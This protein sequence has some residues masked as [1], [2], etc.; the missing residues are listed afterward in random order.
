M[1]ILRIL[2][3]L[4]FYASCAIAQTSVQY[5]HSVCNTMQLQ[6]ASNCYPQFSNSCGYQVTH[7]TPQNSHC[8]IQSGTVS[9]PYSLV[10]VTKSNCTYFVDIA[11]SI[12]TDYVTV[13]LDLTGLSFHSQNGNV[14]RYLL[15]NNTASL[16]LIYRYTSSSIGGSSCANTQ[17]YGFK[18]SLEVPEFL[19]NISIIT[20]IPSTICVGSTFDVVVLNSS[21]TTVITGLQG[22][23]HSRV[24]NVWTIMATSPG[25]RSISFSD[26]GCTKTATTRGLDQP[27]IA[28]VIRESECDPFI[29]IES[30]QNDERYIFEESGIFTEALRYRP[31]AYVQIKIYREKLN[32]YGYYC[33]SLPLIINDYSGSLDKIGCNLVA[34]F[35]TTDESQ[36]DNAPNGQV[37]FEKTL[38]KPSS[39]EELSILKKSSPLAN[40]VVGYNKASLTTIS[41]SYPQL[42]QNGLSNIPTNTEVSINSFYTGSNIIGLNLGSNAPPFSSE[43]ASDPSSF[44][45]KVASGYLGNKWQLSSGTTLDDKLTPKTGV[46]TSVN[47]TLSTQEA[48]QLKR[49]E[50]SAS[51]GI[52]QFGKPSF[53]VSINNLGYAPDQLLV[54]ETT[55]PDGRKLVNFS[56][57]VGELVASVVNYGSVDAEFSYYLYDVFGQLRVVIPPKAVQE[58][59][60]SSLPNFD[61]SD[62]SI[63]SKYATAY[64]YDDKGNQ[65]WSWRPGGA[66][67]RTFYDF[68]NRPV[69]IQNAMMAKANIA[70]I[71][72]Y[73]AHGRELYSGILTN[74]N[75]PS[76]QVVDFISPELQ[77]WLNTRLEEHELFKSDIQNS[78]IKYSQTVPNGYTLTEISDIKYYTTYDID[79]DGVDDYQL[80]TQYQSLFTLQS[81]VREYLEFSDLTVQK[82]KVRTATGTDYTT[83]VYFYDE[84]SRIC[85]RQVIS[86]NGN[87][88]ILTYLYDYA[89]QVLKTH[90]VLIRTTPNGRD[91]TQVLD[92]EYDHAG[93]LKKCTQSSPGN[94]V[95]LAAYSY[96][97]L[98]NVHK[99]VLGGVQDLNYE[100][101]LHGNLLSINQ[102]NS[103]GSKYF[104]EKYFYDELDPTAT[105]TGQL[106]SINGK[107]SRTVWNTFRADKIRSY[108][109]VYDDKGRLKDGKYYFDNGSGWQSGNTQ[110]NYT[111]NTEYDLNGNITRFKRFGKVSSSSFGLI[112]DLTYNYNGNR[113][114][115][116]TDASPQQGFEVK[117]YKPIANSGAN[118][119]DLNGNLITCPGKGISLIEY[120]ISTNLVVKIALANGN[121]IT[122][123]RDVLGQVIETK[124]LL[125]N[126][127]VENKIDYTGG[128]TVVSSDYPFKPEQV[129]ISHPTGRSL[130]VQSL[131]RWINEFHI[132]DKQ[133]SLRIAFRLLPG[134]TF[135]EDPGD[136]ELPGDPIEPIDIPSG[137]R[138]MAV[139][140]ETATMED[141][142]KLDENQKF[143]NLDET[144]KQDALLAV[145]G[146]YVANLNAALGKVVGPLKKLYVHKGD[147]IAADIHT[148]YKKTGSN[149]WLSILALLGSSV[150]LNGIPGLENSP[151]FQTDPLLKIGILASPAVLNGFLSGQRPKAYLKYLHLDKD[152]N[153][154]EALTIPVTDTGNGQW[155]T[156]TVAKKIA[157]EG[158]VYLYLANESGDNVYADNFRVAQ[159][160]PTVVQEQHYY[161]YGLDILPINL[162]PGD[163]RFP[164]FFNHK[165]KLTAFDLQ[166]LDYG[167]RLYDLQLSRWSS[168]DPLYQFASPYDFC[169]GDPVN[170]IDPDGRFV[171][172]IAG[173]LIGFTSGYFSSSG[174][175][176]DEAW[177][178]AAVGAAAG[179]A[180]DIVV[181]S[182]G[183]ATPV[184]IGLAAGAAGGLVGYTTNSLVR[185]ERWDP[186]QAA[187]STVT[188]ALTGGAMGY[189]SQ[190]VGPWLGSKFP[191]TMRWLGKVSET[192]YS[193]LRKF[194][195]LFTQKPPSS[196]QPPGNPSN[197]DSPEPT[198][199]GSSE[200]YTTV[201]GKSRYMYIDDIDGD[202]GT[203]ERYVDPRS[204]KFTDPNTT[205]HH[206]GYPKQFD[207]VENVAKVGSNTPPSSKALVNFS[208][209]NIKG[210]V[211][212][213]LDIKSVH[214][215]IS[216]YNSGAI[217]RRHLGNGDFEIF[218]NHEGLL[219]DL[220]DGVNWRSMRIPEANKHGWN[221]SGRVVFSTDG[222]LVYFTPDHYGTFILLPLK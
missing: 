203:I 48:A 8:Y 32:S 135:G 28:S 83:D 211:V 180:A 175:N 153:L 9:H 58:I 110:E 184:A 124:Y 220:P 218:R 157:Q 186:G 26:N 219:P 67:Q 142:F 111:T 147:S 214:A 21:T 17:Y 120:D 11:K 183:T 57:F 20:S 116:V 114:T 16:N 50:F 125:A 137:D 115:Q 1:K 6:Q 52:N 73:D 188:G 176:W 215:R 60:S 39:R 12:N 162:D 178:Q 130:Y 13:C 141:A 46:T 187:V 132:T 189:V 159:F 30:P 182:M 27:Q 24:G 119:Y 164:F 72:R 88:Q 196:S 77:D 71:V 170:R 156:L 200:R 155:E 106:P 62:N 143:D 123:L 209:L 66:F 144:R 18:L 118:T 80:N 129:Y 70:S 87:K 126:G 128:Q 113:L 2:V 145:S 44:S 76:S 53:V 146:T 51:G 86:Y 74:S 190:Q 138:A 3:W 31:L 35:E 64:E 152:S 154:V 99:I 210:N 23:S 38:I 104:G 105:N 65:I 85:Q 131:Q 89:G 158:T 140:E 221:Y 61:W 174:G 148:Y 95:V 40:D 169:G 94:P 37:T 81:P 177:K 45:G 102:P 195:N 78:G 36:L 15:T 101:D 54:N 4:W 93:R 10:S 163:D 107:V 92:N 197:I 55:G 172:T 173:G 34:N 206:A 191:K 168:D 22:W 49:F 33:R 222:S 14:T 108:N 202:F 59:S 82:F 166:Y 19:N 161:P 193:P 179:L 43:S 121:S 208:I 117:D 41:K 201:S 199:P 198:P 133:G 192:L 127:F 213:Y 185:G 98:G 204:P 5:S 84:N 25:F 69:L 212:T 100:Y 29:V 97:E 96:N 150:S 139:H 167:A 194:R 216:Q 207:F 90:K 217:G 7:A 109:Y 136:P 68:F 75:G 134:G 79:N 103:L 47:R 122:F 171:G 63:L 165:E 42:V 160:T 181:V 149:I 112:D 151:I 56:T 91:V 205:T